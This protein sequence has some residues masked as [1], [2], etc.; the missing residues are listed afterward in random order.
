MIPSAFEY[1]RPT[2]LGEA[3][4][5]LAAGD[6]SAKVLAG[7]QSLLP[8]LKLRMASVDRLI[9]I[10][11]LAELRAIRELPDGGLGIGSMATY[12]DVLAS[13]LATSRVPLL[14]LTIPGIGDVQVR[15]RGTLGGSI[16]HADPAADMPAV[17]LALDA[18]LV[19]RSRSA[20]RVLPATSF[21]EGAFATDCADDELLTEIRIP[22]LPA[23]AKVAFQ[24]LEQRASGYSIVGVAAVLG[25]T[26]GSVT[27]ARIAITGVADIAYR[28]AAVEAALLG[29]TGDAGAISAAAAHAVDGIT[30]NSDIHADATYRAEMARVETRRA[31]EAAFAA[32]D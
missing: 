20:E 26:G 30:V 1:S 22:A 2:S 25:R 4:D 21:F 19:L 29:T 8:L 24:R 32:G 11:D 5:R 10:G 7:G 17:V 18:Q 16:A 15:N 13:D 28:A 9:D 23:D 31:I 14:A 3:L 6:G 27:T 12:A